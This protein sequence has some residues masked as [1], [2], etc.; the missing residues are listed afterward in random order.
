MSRKYSDDALVKDDSAEKGQ[1]IIMSSNP[2]MKTYV[3]PAIKLDKNIEDKRNEI[4]K[5]KLS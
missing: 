5:Q 4:I 3:S 2:M 1:V